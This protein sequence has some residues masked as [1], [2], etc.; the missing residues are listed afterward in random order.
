MDLRINPGVLASVPM[1]EAVLLDAVQQTQL[2]LGDQRKLAAA[3]DEKFLN[4]IFSNGAALSGTL[5]Q[6]RNLKNDHRELLESLD[7][8]KATWDNVS[9]VVA[10]A[11][12]DLG[13]IPL[14][15]NASADVYSRN[16]G[17]NETEAFRK[18]LDE[19]FQTVD[20]DLPVVALDIKQYDAFSDEVSKSFAAT[21]GTF[22]DGIQ[23]IEHPVPLETLGLPRGS[24]IPGMESE[25]D[26]RVA[27]LEK[28]L[29]TVNQQLEARRQGA[30]HQWA[31]TISTTASEPWTKLN[32]GSE[33]R[34]PYAEFTSTGKPVLAVFHG[35]FTPIGQ[36]ARFTL[37]L[38]RKSDNGWEPYGHSVECSDTTGYAAD[39]TWLRSELP[40]GAYRFNVQMTTDSSVEATS[41]CSGYSNVLTI[42]ELR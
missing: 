40:A 19:L 10:E 27:G 33:E 35:T 26:R 28:L 9:H 34:Q 15:A 2:N 41:P 7:K 39:L 37:N 13:W 38:E 32:L 14:G 24:K 11:G 4:F 20:G 8:S 21:G 1:L 3:D 12:V 25:L 31:S 30:S 23:S 17:S 6:F 36:R 5:G 16:S 22:R 42:V 29:A 18:E